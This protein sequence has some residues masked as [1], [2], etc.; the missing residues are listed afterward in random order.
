MAKKSTKGK[1][2]SPKKKGLLARR[3]IMAAKKLQA[4]SANPVVTFATIAPESNAVT[5]IRCIV[6]IASC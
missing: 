2:L 6:T 3:E 1:Q 5:K 4:A